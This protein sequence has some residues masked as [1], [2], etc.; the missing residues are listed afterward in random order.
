MLLINDAIVNNI[1]DSFKVK[2][3]DY[4]CKFSNIAVL[5]KHLN[6]GKVSSKNDF[7]RV[8]LKEDT[9]YT[10]YNASVDDALLNILDESFCND[11]EVKIISPVNQ[12]SL[13]RS[14]IRQCHKNVYMWEHSFKRYNILKEKV[15]Q[16][17]VRSRMVYFVKS[18]NDR[19]V[20]Y[21][22]WIGK[23][24][25]LD[26]I[27]FKPF[28]T[29]NFEEVLCLTAG[30]SRPMYRRLYKG[31]EFTKVDNDSFNKLSDDEA[32]KAFMELI[33]AFTINE[34]IVDNNK[35]YSNVELKE[36]F[37]FVAMKYMCKSKDYKSR[38]FIEN[39]YDKMMMFW[40]PKFYA[41]FKSY[42]KYARD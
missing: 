4:L 5:E 40:E 9:F 16:P 19:A 37:K 39:N 35:K 32:L 21:N 42:M 17:C 34:Y 26:E 11:E 18:L 2:T 7:F 1:D 22:R 24:K 6:L 30:D 10:I 31:D 8:Y 33:Y 20:R 15:I 36:M 12:Y 41:L 23:V 25:K 29:F 28:T 14:I 27:G 3:I 38:L 13:D